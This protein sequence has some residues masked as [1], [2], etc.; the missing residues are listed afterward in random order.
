VGGRRHRLIGLAVAAAL[1]VAAV[2]IAVALGS[3]SSADAGVEEN[4]VWPTA[5][6]ADVGLDDEA[7]RRLDAEMPT[8]NPDV[9]ALL[10]ARDG[11]LAFERY[12]GGATVSERF[13]LQSVTKTVVS[14]LV[15]MAIADGRLELDATLAEVFPSQIAAAVDPRVRRI[16]VRQLLTMTAGWDSASP[17]DFAFAIDPVRVLLGRPLV[18]RPGR[19]FLYDNGSYHLLSAAVSAVT[20]RTAAGFARAR[21]FGPLGV[22]DSPWQA[23]DSGLSL[24]PGGLYLHARDLAKLGQLFLNE[25]RWD[26]RQLVPERYVREST[27]PQSEGGPPGGTRYGYGWWISSSPAGFQATGYG[28]QTL[29]VLPGLDLVVVLLARVEGQTDVG[30]ILY[31]VVDAVQRES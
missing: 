7:L 11:R 29:L 18:D 8:T 17:V 2:A 5:A 31:G 10:V 30:G 19:R 21:L 26:G 25:G 28:G 15:G 23:D 16:T 1:A 13:D 6:P 12:Y 22:G 3:R 20:E 9:L 4:G 24:G 27:R 14:V